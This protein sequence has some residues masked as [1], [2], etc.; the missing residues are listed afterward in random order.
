MAVCITSAA[1]I[2][3]RIACNRIKRTVTL[4]KPAKRIVS[5]IRH[6]AANR[7]M[8]INKSK[9]YNTFSGFVHFSARVD[10]LCFGVAL[11]FRFVGC[12][13]CLFNENRLKVCL[14]LIC[15]HLHMNFA[16]LFIARIRFVRQSLLAFA[17]NVRICTFLLLFM[18][19]YL[20]KW[21]HELRQRWE[22]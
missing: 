19:I 17:V 15:V 9:D 3:Q 12:P 10:W 6:E 5:P 2:W 14:C 16:D 22:N 13:L 4:V 8:Q 11:Y 18:S 21:I 1:C 7:G 20:Y